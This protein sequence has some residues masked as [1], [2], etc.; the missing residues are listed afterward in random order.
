M[1][2]FWFSLDNHTHVYV[3]LS[4]HTQTLQVKYKLQW[5]ILQI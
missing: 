1:K 4:A 3:H 5:S 2:A